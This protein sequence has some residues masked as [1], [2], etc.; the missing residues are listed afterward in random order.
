MAWRLP[1][2]GGLLKPRGGAVP[3]AWWTGVFVFLRA[4]RGRL[5]WFVVQEARSLVRSFVSGG[6]QPA[7]TRVFCRSRERMTS[8]PGSL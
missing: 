4:L 7:A 6:R 8:V 2:A 5:S 3:K 1:L